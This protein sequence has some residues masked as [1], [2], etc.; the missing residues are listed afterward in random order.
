MGSFRNLAF[1]IP[2]EARAGTTLNQQ[3]SGGPRLYTPVLAE[4]PSRPAR[5]GRGTLASEN[6]GSTLAASIRASGLHLQ[7]VVRKVAIPGVVGMWSVLGL[8]Q[9]ERC[10]ARQLDTCWAPTDDRMLI[11]IVAL[12][13]SAVGIYV[14]L[15]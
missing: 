6:N 2:V 14:G 8:I 11:T 5:H 10:N 7:Y 15:P 12:T 13:T 3:L 9:T 4:M 1:R